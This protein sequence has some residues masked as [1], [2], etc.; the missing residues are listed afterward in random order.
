MDATESRWHLMYAA[1][2]VCLTGYV[3]QCCSVAFG[4]S[5]TELALACAGMSINRHDDADTNHDG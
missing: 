1:R 4:C 3:K 2:L 5:L